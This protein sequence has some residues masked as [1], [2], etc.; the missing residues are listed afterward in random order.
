MHIVSF[1]WAFYMCFNITRIY[2]RGGN[3]QLEKQRGLL[4]NSWK[5]GLF[6]EAEEVMVR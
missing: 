6:V 4:S 1:K 2:T 5:G 3:H